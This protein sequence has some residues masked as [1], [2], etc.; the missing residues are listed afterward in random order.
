MELY[1]QKNIFKS[2][3]LDNFFTYTLGR[4]GHLSDLS[5]S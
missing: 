5:D 1:Y 2:K 3:T 4:I